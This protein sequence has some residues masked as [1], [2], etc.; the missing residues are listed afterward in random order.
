MDYFRKSTAVQCIRY[1]E[2]PFWGQFVHQ[3][4]EEHPTARHGEMAIGVR[5]SQFEE[6]EIKQ[7]VDPESLLAHTHS[8]KAITYLRGNLVWE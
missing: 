5:H 8:A 4:C 7:I 2:D 1:F 6:V 3:M